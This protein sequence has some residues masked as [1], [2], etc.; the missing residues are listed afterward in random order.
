MPFDIETGEVK[1][2]YVDEAAEL[3]ASY[4]LDRLKTDK[5]AGYSHCSNPVHPSDLLRNG[6][7]RQEISSSMWALQKN[8]R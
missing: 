7:N 4:L 6:E 8:R 3:T 2:S 1:Q 5:N